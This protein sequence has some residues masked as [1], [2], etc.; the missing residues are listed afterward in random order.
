MITRRIALGGLA[1]GALAA[2]APAVPYVF[3]GGKARRED[4]ALLIRAYR[5]M[6]PGLRRYHTPATLAA[7]D[8][9]LLR[10]ADAATTP[11]MLWLA[12]THYTASVRCGHSYVSQFNQGKTWERLIVDRADRVPFAFRWRQGRM[13]VTRPLADIPGLVA[14]TEIVDLDG[15]PAARLLARLLPLARADGSNDFKRAADVEARGASSREG[16]DILRRLDRDDVPTRAVVTL[17]GPSGGRRTLDVPL[18]GPDSRLTGDPGKKER[19]R[20]AMNDRAVVLTM[21]DWALYNDKDYDWRAVIDAAVDQAIDSGAKAI[22]ADLRG[23]EGG[24][25]CGE[26]LA[27]RLIERPVTPP[28]GIRRVRFRSAP[29]DLLP[30]LDTWDRSFKTL[31]EGGTGPDAEGFYTLPSTVTPIEPKGRRFTGKLIVLVDDAC[32]SATFEFARFVRAARLGTL[33]GEPTGGNRRGINGG[34]YFFVRL[35]NTRLEVDLPLIGF[36]A[37]T[38]QP[39]AGLFPDIAAPVTRA[40]LAAGTDPGMAAAL[41]LV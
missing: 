12:F 31:G 18:L 29:A 33:V 11:G 22:I 36:F 20:V 17:A 19:F 23:N 15:E 37:R 4:A 30:L 26:V 10:D 39:D 32:S 7:S 9:R 27:A 13:I 16:F 24:N 14:G 2:A 21:P 35:P 25:E 41:R 6:H 40:S 3:P 1:G 38:P 5:E 8:E 28:N 34:A